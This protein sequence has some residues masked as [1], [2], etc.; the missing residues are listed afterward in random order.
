VIP[1]SLLDPK[2]SDPEMVI[3]CGLFWVVSSL[4]FLR[5][6]YSLAKRRMPR[7]WYGVAGACAVLA[8]GLG[9]GSSGAMG[10]IPLV[11]FQ[12]VGLLAT[13]VLIIRSGQRGA[14]RWLCGAALIA[15]G[16][17]VLDAPLV[18]EHPELLQW[19]FV[20]ATALEMLAALGML[21]LYYE[22]ARAELIDA[23]RVLAEKSRV[24]A[25]GRVAGGVAHDFNN[26][27]T[28]MQ[29][30]L[31]LI[32]TD[33]SLERET[34]QCL[35]AMDQAVKQ[36]GRLTAQ[37]LSFGRS[38]GVERA[39]I[40]TR[41]V[42]ASTLALLEKVMPGGIRVQRHFHDG[43]YSGTVDRA[44][45]EQIVLNLTTNARDAISGVGTISVELERQESPEARMAL[46]VTDDGCGMDERVLERAFEPFFT[47]KA[48]GRGTGLGLASVKSAV[49][50]LGGQLSVESKPGEGTSVQVELPLMAR[51]TE[52]GR[53][54]RPG[55]VATGADSFPAKLKELER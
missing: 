32:R 30:N 21:T 43:D 1:L 42:V 11:L 19:G 13:G 5:G 24:E 48:V 27:L 14:G 50:E 3:A 49:E 2:Q 4:C 10:M 52:S 9:S 29:G 46:R 38:S 22:H 23:E 40:D 45:L 17:H 37:L 55:S 53:D 34:I 41:E 16:L 31:S 36:A 8:I 15:L 12:S 47:T 33:Q 25:L 35:D 20:L 18:S 7:A 39:T 51:T 6:T 44:L 54:H 26:M 28:V